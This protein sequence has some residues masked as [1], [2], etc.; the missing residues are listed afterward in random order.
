MSTPF[1]SARRPV[2][3]FILAHLSRPSLVPLSLPSFLLLAHLL[4]V[5]L[6]PCVLTF[7]SLSF[8]S[9][10]SHSLY[11]DIFSSFSALCSFSSPFLFSSFSSTPLLLS[12]FFVFVLSPL[13][14]FFVI[15]ISVLVP[16]VVFHF[17]LLPGFLS[18]SFHFFFHV[19]FILR[20]ASF[21]V[22]MSSCLFHFLRLFPA[23]LPLSSTFS[24]YFLSSPFHLII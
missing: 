20:P 23:I 6:F 2:F 15:Q 3:L 16:L 10:V 5:L 11:P 21:L 19:I 14:Y 12:S 8:L 9:S 22:S 7:T 17:S 4:S 1:L 18:S 13:F 24:V